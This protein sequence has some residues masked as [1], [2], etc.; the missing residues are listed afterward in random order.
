MSVIIKYFD[1]VNSSRIKYYNI[2]PKKQNFGHP[3]QYFDSDSYLYHLFHKDFHQIFYKPQYLYFS[4]I[5]QRLCLIT[6]SIQTNAHQF[7]NTL[8]MLISIPAIS[9]DIVPAL[10]I[11]ANSHR[12]R[13]KIVYKFQ[14]HC[15]H[16][17]S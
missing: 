17:R 15:Y 10:L 13:Y 12:K 11:L 3:L 4:I 7:L 9:S 2:I 5:D 6:K 16:L 8:P 1:I 14:Q